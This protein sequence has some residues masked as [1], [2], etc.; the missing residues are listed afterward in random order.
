MNQGE[1]AAGA[2]RLSGFAG[3]VLGWRPGEFWAATPAE[4]GAVADAMRG[5]GE[6]LSGEEVDDLKRMLR[7][8][9]STSFAGPPPSAAFQRQRG[10][11]WSLGGSA[12][13]GEDL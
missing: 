5:E 10:C 12:R 13:T 8:S 7:R 4:L 2:V 6:G 11:H 1:F 3:V 9:P